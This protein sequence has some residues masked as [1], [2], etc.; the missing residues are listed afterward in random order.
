[1]LV[2][3]A[4][5]P[6]ALL[7]STF[8]LALQTTLSALWT[9]GF[10]NHRRVVVATSLLALDLSLCSLCLGS[11]VLVKFF[12][13]VGL[14]ASPSVLPPV[15]LRLCCGL[16]FSNSFFQ[17]AILVD[18]VCRLEDD[19]SPVGS[20]GVCLKFTIRLTPLANS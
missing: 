16:Q 14:N 3:E 10:D 1:M 19:L 9:T 4:S 20:E 2:Q 6:E 17:Q 15:L 11:L 7:L 13:E 5:P 8:L 18:L 12:Q